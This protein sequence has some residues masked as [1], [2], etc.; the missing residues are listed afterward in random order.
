MERAQVGPAGPDLAEIKSSA[1]SKAHSAALERAAKASDEFRRAARALR[2]AKGNSLARSSWAVG[3]QIAYRTFSQVRRS[4]SVPAGFL[5]LFVIPAALAIGYFTFIASSQ[6]VSEARFAVRGGER[7]AAD[8]IAAVTGLG[9][10]TQVQDSLIVTNYLESQAVVEALEKEIDLRGLYARDDIDWLSR[11]SADDPIERLVRY[12]QKRIKISIEAPSGIITLR[13][14]AFSPE[15]ALHIASAAVELSERLV[16]LLSLRARQDAVAEAE[17]ELARAEK[18]LRENRITMRNL[19]NEQATL[20]PWRTAEGLGTLIAELRLEK[21]RMEQELTAAH[22]S[23]VG[24]HAPQVQILRTRIEVIGEQIAGLEREV[25][26]QGETQ[27]NVLAGKITH[28]DQIELEKQ[29][30]EQQYTL[31]AANLERARVNAEEKKVYLATFV[32]PVPAHESTYPKR[33]LFSALAMGAAF[34]FYLAGMAGLG[35][36]RRRLAI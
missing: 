1:L 24:D 12:W 29:I 9:S 25:T 28:F 16:N 31:A 14:S 5:I 30:A 23:K 26:S 20:D 7:I 34:L 10:F 13:V 17:V 27:S 8:P 4:R 32:Q 11:F 22:R 3:A 19:R 36:V 21:I 2:D 15:D 6:Y 35:A 33:L 18:R